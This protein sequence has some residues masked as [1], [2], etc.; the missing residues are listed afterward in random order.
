MFVMTPRPC[1]E[2]AIK[3]KM[4]LLYLSSNHGTN[5]PTTMITP[6]VRQLAKMIWDYHH[7]NRPLQ[8]ADCIF[9][10]GSHDTRV[11]ERAAGL[12]LGGWAPLLIFSGGLGRLTKELW[13]ETEAERFA[14]IAVQK[15][16]PEN[17]ILIGKPF[18]QHRRKCG[19][20]PPAAATTWA[21]S[22]KLHS[23]SKTLHGTKNL[24]H[25]SK[26]VAW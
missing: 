24:C 12:Y 16:V 15:G 13:T 9:V 26:T 20:H 3:T 2:A 5:N 14:K 1:G 6:E 23:G 21:E 18:H 19:V 11:A 17:H 4:L 8:K 25:I 10:L 7:M 22:A